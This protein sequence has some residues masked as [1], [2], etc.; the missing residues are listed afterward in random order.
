MRWH[1]VIFRKQDILIICNN[2]LLTII[3]RLL[4]RYINVS[5]LVIAGNKINVTMTIKD[6][7]ECSD[8]K[9]QYNKSSLSRELSVTVKLQ[10]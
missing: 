9:G 8:A 4:Y 7:K 6:D 3:V 10:L 2:R 1:T 5:F